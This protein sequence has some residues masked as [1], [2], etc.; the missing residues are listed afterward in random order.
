MD[1]TECRQLEKG[2]ETFPLLLL[3]PVDREIFGELQSTGCGIVERR[4]H[5]NFSISIKEALSLFLNR[6]LV[7]PPPPS[8]GVESSSVDDYK[9]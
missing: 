3:V 2:I 9:E 6:R 8:Q 5:T 7:N 1:Q 4:V